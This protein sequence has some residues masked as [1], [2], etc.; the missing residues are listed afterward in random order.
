MNNER[1]LQLHSIIAQ[2]PHIYRSLDDGFIKRQ[3]ESSLKNFLL[4]RLDN[5]ES[6][7]FTRQH[8][9][10][11]EKRLAELTSVTGYYRLK[12]LLRGASDWDE[13]QEFLA[14]VDITLF[15]KHESLLKEI[16]PE[17][18]NSKAKADILLTFSQ[19]D[20][21]CEITSF[22]SIAKSIGSGVKSEDKKIR[23]L[24]ERQPWKIGQD[25]E[26]ELKIKKAVRN[27]LDKTRRQLPLNNLG[28]L[29]LEAGKSAVF[30]L[31]VRKMASK[32]F[33]NRPQLA[34]IMLW[35]WESPAHNDSERLSWGRKKPG[36]CYV[37][38][39]SKF[40]VIGEALL[41]HLNLN[42]EVVG[43]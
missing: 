22:Q 8:L 10:T 24:R 29:S 15:F 2:F 3:C 27:L 28:I 23:E 1:F 21:Y 37:N 39:I 31:D 40:Q 13:Y 41:K 30:D 16:E 38:P 7:H 33:K 32:L 17:L 42:S 6:S 12:P 5:E 35:S 14:Q 18:V 25:I 26:H 20:I 4:K 19:E 43:I 11:L 36:F 9:P 34:L